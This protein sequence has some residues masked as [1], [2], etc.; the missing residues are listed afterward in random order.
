VGHLGFERTFLVPLTLLLDNVLLSFGC[1]YSAHIDA[2]GLNRE[3]LVRLSMMGFVLGTVEEIWLLLLG[4]V[5]LEIFE[6][7]ESSMVT[8]AVCTFSSSA[9]TMDTCC[10]SVSLLPTAGSTL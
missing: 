4:P 10:R 2:I 3:C 9:P 6:C 7:I 5:K 8:T 1:R